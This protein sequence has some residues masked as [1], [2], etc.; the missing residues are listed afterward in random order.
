M[1]ITMSIS[2]S[3]SEICQKPVAS[4]LFCSIVEAK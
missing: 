2:L 3:K 4:A 1:V